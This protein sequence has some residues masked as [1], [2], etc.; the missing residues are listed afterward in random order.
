MNAEQIEETVRE[1]LLSHCQPPARADAPLELSSLSLV[2]LAEELEQEFGFVV[3]ARELLPENFAT[4]E[5]IVAYV[6]RRRS[7]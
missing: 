1:L 7:A 2:A 5:K 6:A 4:L 3:A